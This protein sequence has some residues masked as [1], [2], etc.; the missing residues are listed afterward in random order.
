MKR[1]IKLNE[2][3]LRRI[4][5][6]CVNEVIE[7]GWLKN[8]GLG[9]AI[10]VASSFPQNGN[11]QQT[12]QTY[13]YR[14][15]NEIRYQNAST[16][17]DSLLADKICDI[18]DYITNHPMGEKE[19]ASIFPQAY[20]DRNAN[21]QVWNQNQTYYCG[22]VYGRISIVG[23]IAASKGENPWQAILNKYSKLNYQNKQNDVFATAL[24]NDN[25]IK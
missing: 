11:A 5:E 12:K 8:L 9:T 4:C 25:I 1:R 23:K 18:D 10:A 3:D 13:N 22:K 24:S 15:P 2:A 7:E 21:P 20:K 14:T 19:L 16:K 6:N 17:Q